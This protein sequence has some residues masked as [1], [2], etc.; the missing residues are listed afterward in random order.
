MIIKIGL[1]TI[2]CTVNL[3]WNTWLAEEA[4]VGCWFGWRIVGRLGRRLSALRTH[5]AGWRAIS[6]GTIL[7]LF[8]SR[9]FIFVLPLLEFAANIL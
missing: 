1:S 6:S 5:A 4:L 3:L 2:C 8:T 9:V 7:A